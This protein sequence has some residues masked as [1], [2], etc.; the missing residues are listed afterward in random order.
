L[1]HRHEDFQKRWHYLTQ[2]YQCTK[3]QNQWCAIYCAIG[4]H[5]RPTQKHCVQHRKAAIDW[6]ERFWRPFLFLF[7]LTEFS[8]IWGTVLGCEGQ[9]PN[10][11]Q[12]S[13]YSLNQHY[14]FQFAKS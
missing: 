13:L 7:A 4:C 8:K 9:G 5:F 14:E 2:Q 6:L 1:N 11:P 12:D 3:S 10:F